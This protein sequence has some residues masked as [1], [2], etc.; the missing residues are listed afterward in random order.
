MTKASF[1]RLCDELR[2]ALTRQDTVMRKAIDVETQVCI[3]KRTLSK[4]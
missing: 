2:P 1:I 3:V 4:V